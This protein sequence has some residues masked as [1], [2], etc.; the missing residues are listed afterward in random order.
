MFLIIIKLI[1][2]H[3]NDDCAIN[4]LRRPLQKYLLLSY[5]KNL[6]SGTSQFS[7]EIIFSK[8]SEVS[9][10]L[11]S[12]DIIILSLRTSHSA[13]STGPPDW[14]ARSGQTKP[15]EERKESDWLTDCT[16]SQL[17]DK[18]T[19][20]TQPGWDISSLAQ[21]RVTKFKNYFL[22]NSESALQHF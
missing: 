21:S 4:L 10:L 11:C 5:S 6:A 1:I 3:L 14:R 7:D 12:D 20:S 15:G 19:L 16:S 2:I 13:K 18:P 17:T 9:G 22:F 8:W